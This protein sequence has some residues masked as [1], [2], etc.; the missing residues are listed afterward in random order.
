[1]FILT[2]LF[3]CSVAGVLSSNVLSLPWCKQHLT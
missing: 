2:H 3:R 1:M